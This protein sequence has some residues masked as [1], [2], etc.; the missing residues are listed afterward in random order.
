MKG[1]PASLYNEE[2]IKSIMPEENEQNTLDN[3]KSSLR[4]DFVKSHYH[5]VI[6]VDGVLGG[7]TPN[8][9]IH[10]AFWSELVSIPDSIEY[11]YMSD[12][13]PPEV[14]VNISESF[15]REIEDSFILD[16]ATAKVIFSWLRD[17]I[18][19][20]ESKNGLDEDP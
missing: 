3:D 9:K 8:D 12:E 19:E 4:F 5:R 7:I 17:R 11:S 15:T 1:F 10:M 18:S 16:I 2:P 13:E 14:F 6:H 20:L